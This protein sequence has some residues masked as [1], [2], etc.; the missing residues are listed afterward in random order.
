M[1]RLS[2]ACAGTQRMPAN[3]LHVPCHPL[4]V[5]PLDSR[6]H[7]A[8]VADSQVET[9]RGRV[10]NNRSMTSRVVLLLNK[11]EEMPKLCQ[12]HAN[13]AGGWHPEGSGISNPQ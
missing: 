7:K 3:G 9:P 5:L 11:I 2:I 13:C 1:R 4:F 12:W 8:Q 6:V 10:V